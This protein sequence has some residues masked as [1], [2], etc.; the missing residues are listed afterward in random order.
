MAGAGLQHIELGTLCSSIKLN[1]EE[2]PLEILWGF[3]GSKFIIGFA[4]RKAEDRDAP[5]VSKFVFVVAVPSEQR[6]P[7]A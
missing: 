1:K 6:I 7:C 3:T 5:H 2:D 4:K